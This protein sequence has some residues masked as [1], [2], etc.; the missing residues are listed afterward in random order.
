MAMGGGHACAILDN[1]D[2]KCWGYN[3]RG[4][5]GYGD[6]EHRGDGS[7]E[8]GDTLGSIDV[9]NTLTPT[10]TS[11]QT[12]T[13]TKTPTK[14][15]TVTRSKTPT[16][17]KTRTATPVAGVKEVVSIAMGDS[18]ACAILANDTVKC[19]GNNSSGQLGYGNTMTRGDGTDEM[20]SNLAAVDLG[21]GRTAK[22]ISAGEAHTCVILDNN[23]VKCWGANSSGQLGQGRFDNRG[24]GSG[25]MGSDL[26][27]VDLGSGRTAK[28]ISAGY[29][30]TCAILDD[31]TVKCWGHN[32]LGQLG[33]DDVD[34]RGDGTGEM[35]DDLDS[36]YLGSGRTAKAIATGYYHTCALLDDNSLR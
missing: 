31:D 25:E 22:A 8:M 7:N 11:T 27:A 15:K 33:L 9:N 29:F 13:K 21:S 26:A 30:H 16:R 12:P 5:L 24:D 14:S 34:Y 36:V 17:S 1:Y 2:L 3:P 10:P 6:Q 19:W 4:Q 35:G 28:A 20:G 18:H 23:S 32:G